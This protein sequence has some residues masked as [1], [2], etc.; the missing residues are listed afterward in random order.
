LPLSIR[1]RDFMNKNLFFEFKQLKFFIFLSFICLFSL[2][3]SPCS[4]AKNADIATKTLKIATKNA[5]PFVMQTEGE[6]Q[7]MAVELWKAVS[8]DLHLRF[9]LK[10]YNTIGEVLVAVEKGEADIAIGPISVTA[11]REARL[12]FTQPFF[13]GGEGIVTVKQA[14]SVLDGLWTILNLNFLRALGALAAVILIFGILIWVLERKKNLEQF[15]GSALKGLGQGFWWSAV[16]MT[17]VGYGDKAP[18]TFWGRSVALVWMFAS[19]ITISGFTAAI[20]SSI[21]LSNLQS[22]VNGLE[23]LTK[24]KVGALQGTSGSHFLSSLRIQHKSY[25]DIE[26]ALIALEKNELDAVVHD[27]PI[28][29]YL[30]AQHSSRNLVVLTELLHSEHYAF[31][32]PQNSPLRE[33]INR[34]LLRVLDTPR[35]Q[36]IQDSYFH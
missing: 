25:K 6:Y 14:G 16:T 19:V 5:P 33:S 9:E 26:S 36:Q 21:T 31:A 29:R 20:A 11:D 1:K 35:W 15:G 10:P 24:A 32:L 12:D 22:R 13:Q 4:W 28:L 23:D 2:Y 30:V 18:V 34:S 17:T 8:D 7:G 27:L 3:L